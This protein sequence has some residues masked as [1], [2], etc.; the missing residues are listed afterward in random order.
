LGSAGGDLPLFDDGALRAGARGSLGLGGGGSVAT[1]GGTLAKLALGASLQLT[2]TWRSGVEAG[3]L[4]GG[5]GALQARTLQ[6]WLA[7]GT[8]PAV[9]PS[10]ARSGRFARTDW[11]AV[12]QVH[13]HARRHDGSNGALQTI[14]LAIDRYAPSGAAY[15]TIQAHS[16]L[17]GGA[18]GYSVGLVGGG[19]ASKLLRQEVRAGVEL[20]LGAAGGG[21]VV[22][23][24]GAVAQ[25]LAWAAWAPTP[26]FEWRLALGTLRSRAPGSSSPLAA[27][28]FSR[29]FGQ[30][31][32]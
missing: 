23:G 22:S 32:P 26:A 2:P 12:L 4:R 31:G 19:L 7:M 27:I 11:S 9:G 14:G 18:G 1:A 29:T 10:G 25:A 17:S 5:G 24:G 15:A 3:R 13:A 21:G 20:A 16:A 30:A 6:W 28:Q 8:E